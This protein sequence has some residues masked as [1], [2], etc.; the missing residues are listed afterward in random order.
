MRV[1]GAMAF[2]NLTLPGQP[3]F[4]D[5]PD[6]PG[7][8]L[9]DGAFRTWAENLFYA[10]SSTSITPVRGFASRKFRPLSRGHSTSG[11]GGGSPHP[12][13]EDSSCKLFNAAIARPNLPRKNRGQCA[14]EGA[15]R[16][17]KSR[18]FISTEVQRQNSS[19]MNR[20][21]GALDKHR[22]RVDQHGLRGAHSLRVQNGK[23]CI[24]AIF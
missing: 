14:R 18:R 15:S 3:A 8:S 19:P 7:N 11:V 4:A 9:Q 16:K 1:A 10:V 24:S 6:R 2:G 17:I 20:R 5:P 12:W 22:W 21:G 13:N 23:T